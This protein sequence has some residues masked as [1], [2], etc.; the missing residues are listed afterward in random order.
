[1]LIKRVFYILPPYHIVPV[2]CIT[3]SYLSRS[4]TAFGLN[5]ARAPAFIDEEIVL[6]NT[7]SATTGEGKPI[8]PLLIALHRK[9][10]NGWMDGWMANKEE[11]VI[12]LLFSSGCLKFEIPFFF[13]G[14]GNNITV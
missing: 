4:L 2:E 10:V 7:I 1:M 5:R 12:V 14:K 11:K 3:G 8:L 9:F 13:V 6:Q